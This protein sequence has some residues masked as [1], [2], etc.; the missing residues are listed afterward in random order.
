MKRKL[1]FTWSAAAFA[2]SRA[3]LYLWTF[4]FPEAIGVDEACERWNVLLTVLRREW[5]ARWSGLRVY[6]MHPGG[7]G[8]HIHAV[9]DERFNPQELRRMWALAA[10]CR[11]GRIDVQEIPAERAAYLAKYLGK[12]RPEALKNKRLA[13]PFG[14][15]ARAV[16]RRL[17]DV[18]VDSPWTRMYALVKALIPEPEFAKLSFFKL[19]L[20]VHNGLCRQRG[21]RYLNL[22]GQ[23]VLW[24]LHLGIQPEPFFVDV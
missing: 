6:E 14:D 4:T 13:A 22:H 18:E 9:G 5:G 19:K 20:L 21:H 7:H 10:Q 12:N 11:F 17:S 8:M 3:Y 16:W 23:K 15:R 1:A 2:G 24:E